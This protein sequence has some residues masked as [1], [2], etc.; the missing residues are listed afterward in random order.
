MNGEITM[1]W[2]D[3]LHRLSCVCE[4]CALCVNEYGCVWYVNPKNNSVCLCILS[5]FDMQFC[6]KWTKSSTTH[7]KRKQKKMKN[8][9]DDANNV[10]IICKKSPGETRASKQL[11]K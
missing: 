10:K 3:P 4:H 2:W 9:E 1:M 8:D 11:Q 5:I 6:V 7:I